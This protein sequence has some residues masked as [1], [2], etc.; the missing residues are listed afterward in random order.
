MPSSNVAPFGLFFFMK[1][2]RPP[3]EVPAFFISKEPT[4]CSRITSGIE[5]K[6][7]HAAIVSRYGATASTTL[8]ASSCT[9]IRLPMKT[10]ASATSFLNAS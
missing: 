10:S 2:E 7:M 9:K 3:L 4:F 1:S 6:M 5:G 8:S